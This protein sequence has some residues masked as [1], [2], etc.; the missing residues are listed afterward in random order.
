MEAAPSAPAKR[1][2]LPP[3]YLLGAIIGMAALHLL[4][5]LK[6]IVPW[7]WSMLGALPLL[8]GIALNLVADADL[9]KHGTTVKPFEESASLVTTGAY[10]VCRH[11][12]YVG[13]VMILVGLGVLLGS[14]TPFLVVPPFVALMGVAFVRVEERMMEARFGDAWRAYK[15]KVGRWI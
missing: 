15:A 12:M 8:A 1:R 6:R 4:F 13:F 9:K 11:P 10:R 7:P 14:A 5:P 2:A 3:T